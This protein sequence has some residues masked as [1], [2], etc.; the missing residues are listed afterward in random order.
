[1]SLLEQD[2]TRKGRINKLFLEP[3]P[4]FDAGDN[5]K[6]KVKAIINNVVYAKKTERHLPDLYYLVSWKDYP[7]EESTWEP[8][9]TLMHLLK[10][11][12]TFHKDHLVKSIVTS[13]FLKSALPIAKLSVKPAKL[14]AKQ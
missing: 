3:E 9:S 7:K 2:I 13:L 6:Y 4:E 11:I 8:F 14:S 1:M 10:V 5:K 12:S